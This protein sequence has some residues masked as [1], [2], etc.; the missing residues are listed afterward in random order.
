MMFDPVMESQEDVELAVRLR[1]VLKIKFMPS[2]LVGH[3]HKSSFF[4]IIKL[5]IDR[6]YWTTKIFKKHRNDLN[7]DDTIMTKSISAEGFILFPFWMVLQFV[8]RPISE[9]FFILVSEVSWRV[10]IVWSMLR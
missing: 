2:I 6:A 10:G 1:R 9:V 4:D 5:N 7:L 8:K 3:E